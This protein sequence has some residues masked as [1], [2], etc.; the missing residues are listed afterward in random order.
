MLMSLLCRWCLPACL[1]ACLPACRSNTWQQL[2]PVGALPPARKMHT[3]VKVSK[4]Q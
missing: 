4:G 1:L 3:M 2:K